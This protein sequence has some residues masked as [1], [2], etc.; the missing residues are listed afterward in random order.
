MKP[1]EWSHVRAKKW[2]KRLLKGDEEEMLSLTDLLLAQQASN[3]FHF[4]LTGSAQPKV[5]A[6]YMGSALYISELFCV[7]LQHIASVDSV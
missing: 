6:L 3:I 4:A 1:A 7:K 2:V 5:S